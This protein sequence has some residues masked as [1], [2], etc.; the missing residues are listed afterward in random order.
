M[1]MIMVR[2][3]NV[4]LSGE[5]FH[6]QCTCACVLLKFLSTLLVK[7]TGMSHLYL[8]HTTSTSVNRVTKETG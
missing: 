1:M 2:M 5:D 6:S 3:V 4:L 7:V 8:S